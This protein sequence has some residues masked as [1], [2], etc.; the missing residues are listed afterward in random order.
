MGFAGSIW[1]LWNSQTV[2]MESV[3]SFFQEIHL[4][5]RVRNKL[6]LLTAIYAS[7]DYSKRKIL[8]T[9]LMDL[10]PILNLP[11]LV[12]GDFNDIVVPSEKFRRRPPSKVKINTL[13]CF[14][15]TC[16]LVDLG[17]VGPCFTWTNG[18]I[19]GQVIRT[20]IDRCH[21]T[22]TWLNLFSDTKVQ[23]LPR[24]MSDHNSIILVHAIVAAKLLRIGFL[25]NSAI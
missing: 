14:L 2:Y 8:W 3:A 1:V 25:A 16:R 17:F 21:A 18:R 20:N 4:Q 12:M 22:S 6:F 10:A 9:S 11:W 13:N 7:S 24:P 5:V 23:H 15:N 19:N